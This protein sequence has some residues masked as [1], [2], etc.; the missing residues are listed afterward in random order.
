MKSIIAADIFI[1]A[2]PYLITLFF[3]GGVHPLGRRQ[4]ALYLRARSRL[5]GDA[6]N[7]AGPSLKTRRRV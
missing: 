5:G 3:P 1:S 2:P 7:L 6:T 4:L